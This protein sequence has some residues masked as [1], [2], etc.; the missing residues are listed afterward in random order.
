MSVRIHTYQTKFEEDEPNYKLFHEKLEA[1]KALNTLNNNV[2]F[3][4][5]LHKDNYPYIS[6]SSLTE[7]YT[8]YSPEEFIAMGGK[9]FDNVLADG[10]MDFVNKVEPA[11]FHFYLNLEKSRRN[12][13]VM[14]VTHLLVHKKGLL[15]PAKIK[16]TPFLFDNDHNIWMM[17]GHISMSSPN[18]L[19][20]AAISMQDTD[21]HFEFDS[22]KN[23]FVKSK[24]ISLTK[25]EKIILSLSIRGYFEKEI[26]DEFGLS[27]YTIKTHKKNILKKF[28]AKNINDAYI[29]ARSKNHI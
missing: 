9:V 22:E 1:V 24:A 25:T 21:E 23:S 14:E 12:A 15:I 16:L 11:M 3:I 13:M 26:A 28:Q 18:Q 8:G 27:L 29:I 6:E 19:K 2:L 4:K 10:E 20:H 5:D 7:A 17:L